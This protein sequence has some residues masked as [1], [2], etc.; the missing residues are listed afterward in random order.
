MANQAE[1]D[2]ALV[3]LHTKTAK[4]KALKL[5]FNFLQK[6]LDQIHS[7]KSL[8]KFSHNGKQYSV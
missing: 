6:V 5:Q 2:N 8:L 3:S 1:V 7:D 4:M